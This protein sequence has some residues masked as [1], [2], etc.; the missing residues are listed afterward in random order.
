[1][2]KF[3]SIEEYR[4]TQKQRISKL[5]SLKRRGPITTAKYMAA[6]LRSLVPRGTESH[7]SYPHMYQTI[8][9]SRNKVSAS[10]VN[11]NTGFPYIHWVNSTPGTGLSKVRLG[12]GQKTYS[13]KQVAKAGNTPGF[14]WIAQKRAREFGRDSMINATRNIISSK[15]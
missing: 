6:Q 8:K 10:G 4:T 9:R 12:G 5:K 3:N 7:P 13:Y 11:K 2:A 14:Y 15:F 1:M